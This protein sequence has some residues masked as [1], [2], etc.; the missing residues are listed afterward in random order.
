[1]QPDLLD[2]AQTAHALQ[3]FRRRSP[4]VHCMTNDVVQ[5]FTANV[6]LALGASPAMV[7]EPEEAQQFSAITDALLINVGTLTR[8]RADAMRAAIDSARAAGT[9]LDT[10]SRCCRRADVPYAVLPTASYSATRRH[11]R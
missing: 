3:Q 10:G 7:I 8:E 1:M 5:T 4:L 11:S 9:P 6:L 2:R